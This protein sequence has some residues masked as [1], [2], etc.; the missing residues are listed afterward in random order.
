[1]EK[2]HSTAVVLQS[3][4]TDINIL[5]EAIESYDV[6][7]IRDETFYEYIGKYD[8]FFA[9]WI[10]NANNYLYQDSSTGEKLAMSP[11]KWYYRGESF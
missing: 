11:K 7:I 1:M 2:A 3:K 4:L 6:E 10:D 5:N 8:N 9:G